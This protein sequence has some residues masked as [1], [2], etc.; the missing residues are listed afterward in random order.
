MRPCRRIEASLKLLHGHKPTGRVLLL[1]LL[2]R[3]PAPG[4][5][6]G[7]G[8]L[9]WPSPL[10]AGILAVNERLEALADK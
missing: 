5:P 8:D 2:P 7:G 1:A 3:V 4:A 6:A 10:A 9:P